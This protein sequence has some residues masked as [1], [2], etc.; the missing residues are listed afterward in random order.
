MAIKAHK[1]L[2]QSNKRAFYTPTIA[3]VADYDY[4]ITIV[5]PGEPLPIPGIEINPNPKWNAAVVVQIPIFSGGSRKHQAQKTE[6][7]LYQLQENKT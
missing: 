2:L 1:R 6:I 4:P 3:A 7:G 5:N